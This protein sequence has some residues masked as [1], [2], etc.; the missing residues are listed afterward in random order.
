[1][2]TPT[3]KILGTGGTIA[4]KGEDSATTAGYELNFSIEDLINAIPDLKK[5]N[6]NVLYQEVFNLY[7]QEL[8]STHL[9]LLHREIL[10]AYNEEGIRY[11]V[12]T[13]GTDTLEETA[14]FLELT[15]NFPDI[16]V[17]LTGSMRP[18]S[19][20]SSDGSFNLYQ[21]VAVAINPESVG[22]GVLVVLNDNIGSGYY[23]T[24]SNANSLD[25]FKTSGQGYLGNFV[26]GKIHYFYPPARPNDLHFEIDSYHL[27]RTIP[28]AKDSPAPFTSKTRRYELPEV[29]IFYNYQGFNPMLV[30]LAVQQM[31]CKALVFATCGAGSL[32]EETNEILKWVWDKFNIPVIYSLR[33]MSGIV[34]RENLP[35]NNNG[36]YYQGAIASGYLNPQKSRILVQL[37]L[38]AGYNID[39][40]KE[41][42]ESNN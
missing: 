28:F 13:H 12:I 18:H 32:T 36:D 35:K 21:S 15:I 19:A 34:P 20:L 22:R 4:S 5:L 6:A 31:N 8:N 40:I 33:S 42:F 37:A 24:K 16:V 29:P 10:K 7:S 26:N 39:Q 25:T 41:V 2:T 1:M 11:F 23:I 17:V 9:L 3:V 14:F 27:T 38:H 30:E